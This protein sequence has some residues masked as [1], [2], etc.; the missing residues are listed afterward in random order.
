MRIPEVKATRRNIWFAVRILAFS[1]LLWGTAD[2]CKLLGSNRA[3]VA[4]LLLLEILAMA[5]IGDWMLAVFA[6]VFASLAF[7]FYFIDTVGSFRL[8]SV[9]GTVTFAAMVLTALTGSQLSLRAQ[10]RAQEAIGRREEMERL[11][12]LGRA[13]LVANTYDEAA[14]NAVRGVV[15]LFELKGAVLRVDAAPPRF[16]YG[17]MAAGEISIVTIDPESTSGVLEL[18]GPPPSEE[19]R[20]ALSSLIR[21]ALERA[22]SGEAR[23]E[24]EAIRRGEE[25]QSTVLSALAHN[26]KTP[27]TSIKAAASTLRSES[28]RRRAGDAFS[29]HEREM[30]AV[31]DEEADRLNQLIRESLD[32]AALEVRRISPK[33]EECM[34]PAMVERVVARMVG[35]FGRRELIIEV[36]EDLPPLTGDSFLFEQMLVQVVDNAWKYSRPGARIQISGMLAGSS[37]VL[38]VRNEGSEIPES[39]RERIFDRFYRGNKDRSRVE[40]TGQGLAIARTIVEAY[41]GKVW[42]DLE[43]K[44]PAFHF[45]LP[46]GAIGRS[47]DRKQNHLA[48]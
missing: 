1:L 37:I 34:V 25:F 41:E 24:I 47:G 31:I 42:L 30:V 29:T 9:E 38:T 48:N 32:L 23:A 16:Q 45:A 17:A 11:N 19:V 26:F 7:S 4:M 13:L 14:E 10:R 27:L 33:T 18:Y 6:S 28:V 20:N 36:P 40:G 15:E 2:A 44:G 8:T 46:L 3:T 35:F 21:L 39:D 5:T 43:P 22:R 12:Q